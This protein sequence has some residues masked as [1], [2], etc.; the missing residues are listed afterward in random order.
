MNESMINWKTE[1]VSNRLGSKQFLLK[2]RDH[3]SLGQ[4]CTEDWKPISIF[5][6]FSSKISQVLSNKQHSQQQQVRFHKP[7]EPGCTVGLGWASVKASAPISQA[8]HSLPPVS[9]SK[10]GSSNFSQDHSPASLLKETNRSKRKRYK[11]FSF[12]PVQVYAS[13]WARCSKCVTGWQY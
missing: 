10:R 12:C 4:N 11:Q 1:Q 2:S 3:P 13:L 6:S 5:P 7:Q 8:K 9:N